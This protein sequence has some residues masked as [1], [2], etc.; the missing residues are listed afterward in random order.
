MFGLFKASDPSFNI[1][2]QLPVARP[3]LIFIV[4]SGAI[5][6][7]CIVVGWV[8]LAIL[9][10]LLTS[11]VAWF[12]RDPERPE[13]PPGF[14]VSPADGLIIKVEDTD[15]P[16][17]NTPSKK[18]SIFM[19]VFDVHVNRVPVS[20]RLV[21]QTYYP[22]TFVNASFDKA[23]KHNE[24]NALILD[25]DE[26]QITM[27]QIAGLV[28]RRIVSWVEE[29]EN[30]NRN[31]RYGMIRFGSRVDLYL[32]QNAEI[33]VTVGQKVQAGWSPIWRTQV[34]PSE[35]AT[36]ETANSESMTNQEDSE[37]KANSESA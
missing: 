4:I 2:N 21:T 10:F 35:I 15:N 34:K 6:L 22:G 26:G 32:P 31:Q 27:V 28:A 18:I 13:P 5:L 8:Y 16:Y 29:G 25:T 9:C 30:L 12:F 3:G 14:G 36:S 11:F 19:N 1:N 7:L 37:T 33:M 17:T 24:R 20:G 23:S